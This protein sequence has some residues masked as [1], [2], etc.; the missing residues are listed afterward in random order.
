MRRFFT[1][2]LAC[3]ALALP[4][5]A[6][7][8]TTASAAA[9]TDACASGHVCIYKGDIWDGSS[10]HA[11]VYDFY[12]YRT[13]NVQ[14]LV[15]DYTILNCQ[16]G[17]ARVQGWTGYNATGSVAWD[18]GNN[19]SSGLWTDLTPTNSVRVYA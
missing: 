19:C 13:Y 7:S 3:L 10:N 9:Q 4:M 14:N 6:A 12:Y 18:I 17:G 15:G 11:K 2:L 16:T 5:T 1:G 8:T